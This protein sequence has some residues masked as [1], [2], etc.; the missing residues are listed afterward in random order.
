[1][2]HKLTL[3]ALALLPLAAQS[4]VFSGEIR[5]DD[6]QSIF[7]PPSNS[8]PV[9][10]RY[11]VADGTRVKPGD[12]LLRIDAAQAATQIRKADSDADE[13]GAKIDKETADLQL[14]A[15]DAELAAVDT[16]AALDTARV[17]AALPKTLISALDFD[18]YQAE[19]TRT[20]RDATAKQQQ[21]ADARAAALRRREDGKLE[22][23]KL[24]VTRAYY[25][26]QVDAAEVRAERAGTVVHGF[27]MFSFGSTAA[28]GR[29][30]EGSS[31]YPGNEVGQVVDAGKMHVRAYAFAPDRA[32]LAVGQKMRLAFDALPGRRG[33]GT[34]STIAGAADVKPEWGDGRYFVVEIDLS[35]DSAALPLK[36]GMSV[37][38]ESGD[39]A[40]S[41]EPAGG[42]VRGSG[43]VLADGEVYARS[44]AAISPPQ[45]ED[46]W[47]MT[48]T[49]MATDGKLVKKGEPLVSFDGGEVIKQ[50]SAKQ[51][52]LTE[53]LRQQEKLRLELAE[54][55]RMESVAAAE[56]HADAVKA[57]RKANQ[58]E[59]ALAGVEYKKLVIARRKAEQRDAVSHEHER[60]AAEERAAEQ[61]LA[62]ADVARLKNEVERMQ[63]AVNEL[64]VKAPR[65]GLFLHASNW[66]G[67]KIDTGTQI[68]RGQSVGDIPDLATLAVRV[69]LPERELARVGAGNGVRVLLDGGASLV[70][71]VEEV[72]L[73]V[74][75][76]SR[77]EPV[78]VV[79]VR[80]ALD[81]DS[82]K[83]KPGQAVRVE[84][85]PS[86]SVEQASEKE[87][88]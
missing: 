26:A 46:L 1:M 58:P 19:R 60:V 66:K 78:P 24:R 86:A 88:P 32:G 29:Y 35:A 63:A 36:P 71:H 56:A 51:N 41:P 49:Q 5:S 25:Q 16:Q 68:W 75:S 37:R 67:E 61:R 44:T 18:R 40:K 34:I 73:S 76:K 13:A 69:R 55:A 50:L 54:K 45:V 38:V 52:E 77:V 20:E 4:A 84:I 6:A 57:Q 70:G 64:N 27:S 17:D 3:L 28:G 74:H 39:D 62:D 11:Y 65:D 14:K 7:T 81:G 47:Q 21:L 22:R 72:G 79:D 82:K 53:K 15:V 33:E 12:A 85:V 31:A 42:G 30:E 59:S 87:A 43:V 23:E 9:V 83:L 48:V 80:V 10:L 2:R 8:S